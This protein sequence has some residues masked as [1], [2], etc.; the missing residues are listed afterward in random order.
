VNYLQRD[1]EVAVA[2]LNR[3]ALQR[4]LGRTTDVLAIEVI[5]G[6]EETAAAK[7]GLTGYRIKLAPEVRAAVLIGEIAVILGSQQENRFGK[8]AA[9]E[10]DCTPLGQGLRHL[11][12]LYLHLVPFKA[13]KVGAQWLGLADPQDSLKNTHN[14][15]P[16]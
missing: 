14:P 15:P 1:Y 13:P 8:S 12:K 6:M 3:I 5:G 11:A 2:L 16:S 4:I 9:F 7:L 10:I